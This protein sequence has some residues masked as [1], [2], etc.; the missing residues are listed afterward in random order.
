MSKDF[1]LKQRC[2]HY[3][4]KEWVPIQ[5]DLR[6]IFPLEAPSSQDIELRRNGMKVPRNG[7]NRPA[8]TQTSLNG[9][10]RFE[11][12]E[13]DEF[14]LSVDADTT[15]VVKLP[16]GSEVTL[17]AVLQRLWEN[18]TGVNIES[19]ERGFSI[20]TESRGP[21]SSLHFD[22]GSAHTVLGLPYHRH[23]QG[24]NIFPGWT[25][26]HDEDA[27]IT[28]DRFIRLD[29][30]AYADD[31]IY[32]V[33][34][35]T[36]QADCRRCQGFGI[37]F[38]IRFDDNGAPI[39]L[40]GEELLLQ[41][42]EKITLTVRGSN[43]FHQWYGTS[44]VNLVGEKAAPNSDVLT[45]QMRKEIA[46]AL[47]RYK[48]IK[49]QQKRFQSV[50]PEEFLLNVLSIDIQQPPNSPSSFEIKIRVQ[51]KAGDIGTTTETIGISSDSNEQF[52]LIA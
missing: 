28:H 9:P 27:E 31:N 38:D 30:P 22:Q 25:I 12:D 13:D 10:F 18:L 5:P 40:T 34:Y 24:A 14:R 50:P 49:S 16:L 17:D 52:Q 7:L 21:A 45:S 39:T 6:S 20:A 23:I 36:R 29:R 2:P 26:Q 11:K 42:I 41:E 15:Q 19:Q 35:F 33:S 47:D 1:E 8:K 44:L 48:D 46:E 32:E 37:E 51:N 43:I 3:V 4:R